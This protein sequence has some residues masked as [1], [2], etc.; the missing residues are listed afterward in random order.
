M[1]W[2]ELSKKY[3]P[4]NRAPV[5]AKELEAHRTHILENYTEKPCL[6]GEL[7][8][9]LRQITQSAGTDLEKLLAIEAELSSYTY[10][11]NPG[12]LPDSVTDPG[13]FLDYFLLDSRQGYCCHFATA[14][15]LLARAEGLSARYVEGFCVPMTAGKSTAVFSDM[16]H[17][18]PD[19][20]K[21]RFWKSTACIFA[22]GAKPPRGWA[23]ALP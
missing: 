15:V 21:M 5:T 14:F 7:E 10:T 22:A 8:E 13:A 11:E 6:S 2:N 16:A 4:K 18:W 23:L 9:Y 1:I 3:T 17:A 19:T 20:T 12:P